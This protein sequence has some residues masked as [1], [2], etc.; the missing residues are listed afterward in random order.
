MALLTLT[1]LRCAKRLAFERKQ[2]V[3]RDAVQVGDR[4]ARQR[5]RN[6]L[7]ACLTSWRLLAAK[8]Q[9]IGA[10]LQRRSLATLEGAFAAWRQFLQHQVQGRS[11]LP[12]HNPVCS[13]FS[14]TMSL[15][16]TTLSSLLGVVFKC[17]VRLQSHALGRGVGSAGSVSSAV[18]GQQ[19]T[20]S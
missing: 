19:M 9:A 3:L 18:S 11:M 2:R 8:Y 13:C 16:L 20:G 15:R 12:S 1:Q 4:M 17:Q 14:K 6:S 5:R 10:A 7:G